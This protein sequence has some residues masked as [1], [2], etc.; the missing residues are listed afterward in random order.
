MGLKLLH[1]IIFN[2]FISI[3]IEVPSIFVG[4]FLLCKVNLI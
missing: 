3:Q 1:L 2:F 4:N